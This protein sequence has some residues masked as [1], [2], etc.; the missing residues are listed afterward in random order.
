MSF[1]FDLDNVLIVGAPNSG[2]MEAVSVFTY[3]ADV[4]EYLFNV[5]LPEGQNHTVA[6]LWYGVNY[7]KSLQIPRLN[8]GG[9][10]G[11]IGE[12]KRR[13]G[14]KEL[15]LKCLKQV[16]EPEIY[17]ELCRRTNT[18]PNDRTGYFP[19]YRQR[20]FKEART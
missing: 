20:K 12:F 19:A 4:G 16:Y 11:G 8:L 5:S 13:F 2:Q 9:G 10:G 18:N 1:L 17:K 14:G 7:L 3:T 6:L 15:A